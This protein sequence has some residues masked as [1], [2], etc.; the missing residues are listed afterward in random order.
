MRLTKFQIYWGFN[1]M[2]ESQ[3]VEIFLYWANFF[4]CCG[5]LSHRTQISCRTIWKM[6]VKVLKIMTLAD[7]LGNILLVSLVLAAQDLTNTACALAACK[8]TQFNAKVC[9]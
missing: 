8:S 3:L 1:V 9:A 7:F 2:T 6:I 5:M 4:S